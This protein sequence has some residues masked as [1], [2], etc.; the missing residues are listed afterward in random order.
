MDAKTRHWILIGIMAACV[1]CLLFTERGETLNREGCVQVSEQHVRNV[2]QL[3]E[4]G[5]MAPG[6]AKHFPC[7]AKYKGQAAGQG[8]APIPE[9]T[10]TPEQRR[11]DFKAA[12]ERIRQ[13]EREAA[14][15][16]AAAAAAEA[17]EE[18][19]Q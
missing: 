15:E 13:R 3:I 1:Y 16:R 5:R 6:S 17:E 19:E 8:E 10:L 18:E 11:A 9:P 14:A 2:E 12:V 4:E 7:Y